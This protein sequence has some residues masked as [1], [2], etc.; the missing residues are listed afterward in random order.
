MARHGLDPFY[1]GWSI[2]RYAPDEGANSYPLVY[3]QFVSECA[4]YQSAARAKIHLNAI[5][6]DTVYQI[7]R[8]RPTRKIKAAL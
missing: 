8:R 3:W 7:A 5:S 4:D 1:Q 6:P 2:Y